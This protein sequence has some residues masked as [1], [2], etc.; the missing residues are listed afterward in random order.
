M[1]KNVNATNPSKDEIHFFVSYSPF[2][3]LPGTTD[4]IAATSHL[5]LELRHCNWPLA[6]VFFRQI[7]QKPWPQRHCIWLHPSLCSM[8]IPH[9]GHIRIAG[10]P[11]TPITSFFGQSCTICNFGSISSVSCD[12]VSIPTLNLLQSQFRPDCVVQTLL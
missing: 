5:K 9:C 8:S 10:H 3:Y 6:L 12:M 1:V 11:G 2:I 4:W 7:K